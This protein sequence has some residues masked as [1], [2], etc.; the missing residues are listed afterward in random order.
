MGLEYHARAENHQFSTC[1]DKF[2]DSLNGSELFQIIR[3]RDKEIVFRW[4]S[5]PINEKWPEDALV[6]LE[7][8]HLYLIIHGAT[9]QAREALL[10]EINSLEPG[11]TFEEI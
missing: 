5:H 4:T 3:D 11:I 7:A 10:I 1:F 8:D 6:R 2:R 9:R